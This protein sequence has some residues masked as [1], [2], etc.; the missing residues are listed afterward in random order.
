MCM[1]LQYKIKISHS[2]FA[3]GGHS[4]FGL[5][6]W[7]FQCQKNSHKLVNDFVLQ[8][9]FLGILYCDRGGERVVKS[10]G[11]MMAISSPLSLRFSCLQWESCSQYS[12]MNGIFGVIQLNCLQSVCTSNNEDFICILRISQSMSLPVAHRTPYQCSRTH[13]ECQ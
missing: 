4:E 3:T 13:H 7:Q 9:R 6:K 8:L 5:V 10:V 1:W 2:I 11:E 12:A